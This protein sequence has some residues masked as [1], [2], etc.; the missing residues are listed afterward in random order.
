MD[1]DPSK[2]TNPFP[3]NPQSLIELQTN[4]SE[5]IHFSSFIYDVQPVSTQAVVSLAY[6]G[7]LLSWPNFQ[8]H[9]PYVMSNSTQPS[10]YIYPSTSN[11]RSPHSNQVPPNCLDWTIDPIKAPPRQFK[12]TSEPLLALGYSSTI[13]ENWIA[14]DKGLQY[15]IKNFTF[16]TKKK[17]E[18]EIL[19]KYDS[20]IVS[21][22]QAL[23]G[24]Y[25][26]YVWPAS[27]VL[28][29][30]LWV[31]RYEL[32]G[33]RILEVGSGTSL[34]GI[35][36][37]KCGAIVTLTDDPSVPG[38]IKHIQKCCYMN[39]L[40]PE[41][42]RVV[43]LPW[44]YFFRDTLNLGPFDLI[45]GSDCFYEPNIFEDLIVTISYLLERNPMAKFMTTYH[46]RDSE[47]SI[48]ELA[49]KWK[50]N[51]THKSLED[52]GKNNELDV[53]EL[54]KGNDIHLV[55]ITKKTI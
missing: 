7:P 25:H 20:L 50:L 41:Q 35:V 18:N 43:G 34:P 54:M 36:A 8:N 17:D 15:S 4:T 44:G 11:L 12:T 45:I 31:H 28:A 38:T 16:S 37:A 22:P 3:L 47:F 1:S 24:D 14:G 29:W 42:I 5:G 6:P 46:E 27:P 55:E 49:A 26:Y 2:F 40:Y 13:S 52:L 10:S 51:C 9:P 53:Y 32:P 19:N 33:K 30:I 39:G 23:E 48:D 21:I